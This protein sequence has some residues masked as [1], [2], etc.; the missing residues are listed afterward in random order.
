LLSDR[1]EVNERSAISHQ[2]PVGRPCSLSNWEVTMLTTRAVYLIVILTIWLANGWALLEHA[3]F[4]ARAKAV[5]PGTLILNM[6]VTPVAIWA[7]YK[8]GEAAEEM[9]RQKEQ[10]RIAAAGAAAEK[11][12]RRT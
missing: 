8:S 11:A 12:R 6:I 4:I 5:L 10:A 9:Y 7:A 2:A 3:G 1:R